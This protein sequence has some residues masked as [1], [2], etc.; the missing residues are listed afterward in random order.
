M[1]TIKIHVDE[2]EKNK[3]STTGSNTD[4]DG[5]NMTKKNKNNTFLKRIRNQFVELWNNIK[6]QNSLSNGF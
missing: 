3:P 2:Y 4:K 5:N 6:D 1:L